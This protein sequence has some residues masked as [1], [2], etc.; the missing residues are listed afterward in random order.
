MILN[1]RELHAFKAITEHGSVGRAADALGLTQP[2][3][4]RILKRLEQQVGVP[5]FERHAQGVALTAYGAALEPHAALML[6][7]SAR[8][9]SE[10]SEMRGLRKG[11][12]RVGAV[13]SAVESFLPPAIDALLTQY[14]GIQVCIVEGLTD[15]LAA[16]LVKGDIDLAVAFSMPET[17]ELLLVCESEWQEGC[18]V[19]AA[20]DHPLRRRAPL[21]LGDL[22]G[23]RW[24][25]P[26]RGMAPREEWQ[27]VFRAQGLAA[28]AVTVE[29]RS[30]NAMRALVSRC[31]FLSW[32]PR[33]LLGAHLGLPRPIDVL[34]VAGV[35]VD[36]TF[37]IYRRRVG[38]LS[39]AT[40]QLRDQLLRQVES[41]APAT[42]G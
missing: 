11:V 24:V 3:L 16:W 1:L 35:F 27:Q 41:L 15:E 13:S 36:R 12:V 19:V 6:A 5:L 31:G 26:P 7:E 33:L 23:E 14:P 8:A 28:P 22:A 4:T 20:A 42:L 38:T 30:V 34:P 2:A 37:A 40:V 21:A 10:L 18:H 29:A 9:V 25:L 32:M 17:D 39:P